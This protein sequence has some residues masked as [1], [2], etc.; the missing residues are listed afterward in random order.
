MQDEIVFFI[1]C[2]FNSFRNLFPTELLL[3]LYYSFFYPHITHGI[4]LWGSAAKCHLNS[5]ETMQKKAIRFI[6]GVSTYA[7]TGNLF[8]PYKILKLGDIYKLHVGEFMYSQ[9]YNIGPAISLFHYE[10]KTKTKTKKKQ[11]CSLILYTS[12]F[13]TLH[14]DIMTLYQ[15]I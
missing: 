2:T 13:C 9:I 6:A 10:K 5:I 15:T 11:R 3:K 8:S 12:S 4:V 1:T 7:H 14:Q